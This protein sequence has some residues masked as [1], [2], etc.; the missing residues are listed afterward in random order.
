MHI[1]GALGVPTVSVFGSGINRW[2]SPLGNG[3]RLL[4]A[5]RGASVLREDANSVT[6]FDVAGVG[7][8]DVLDAVSEVLGVPAAVHP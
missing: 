4:T 2:F 1:A 6:P 7:T 8:S 5:E 3:H